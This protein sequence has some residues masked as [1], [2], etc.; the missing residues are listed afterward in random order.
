M[1]T[2]GS[3]NGL[4]TDKLLEATLALIDE[5][6]DAVKNN[7]LETRYKKRGGDGKNGFPYDWQVEFHERGLDCPERCLMAA[8]QAG[9]SDVGSAE[10]AVHATGRYP[11]WWRGR[12]FDEPVK[13]WVGSETNEASRDIVQTKL[14]GPPG[15]IG[16]GWL[17]K[18]AIFGK[19]KNRQ[20]GIDGVIDYVNIQ[21]VSGGLSRIQFKTY[22][23]DVAKWRGTQQHII[24]FDE[25]P[26][27][28]IFVEGQTRVLHLKGMVILTFTPHKGIGGVV[29][30]FQ[31]GGNGIYLR[32]ATWDDA[33][34]LS[35]TERERLWSSY[36][37]HERET[38]A[39][40]V[41]MLGEGKVF[42]V[43]ESDI[44][45]DNREIPSWWRRV[46]GCDF[47]IDHPAAGCWLAYD[48]DADCVY[49]YDCYRK[50]GELPVYHAAEFNARG[51]WIPVAWPHDG[52]QRG[53]AD[54][55]NL[56]EQYMQYGANMTGLSSRY[57]DDTG[58]PQ[59]VEPG[60]M[61]MLERMKT[62]RLKVFKSC[63]NFMDELRMYHR[64]NGKVVKQRDDILDAC[65]YALM[66]LRCATSEVEVGKPRQ[67][68]AVMEYDPLSY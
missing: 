19:P 45:V 67:K 55:R 2:N 10:I 39:Q 3:Y 29:M 1:K 26:P 20:C 48:P 27:Q 56:M 22:E 36:P 65:R 32:G 9:K 5:K 61:E 54:G 66:M 68:T 43:N 17:P 28:D 49:V 18:S 47:G 44:V 34:H 24:W 59:P 15:E 37:A 58:G 35:E 11:D 25:E 38:R 40:G 14:M 42:Q 33:P 7:L 64:K 50:S 46:S 53:K 13:V 31:E 8:N 63:V 23:Q 57:D 60:L 30:H 4:S 21:H 62:G 6:R 52:L 12:K 16:S 41:P 51:K